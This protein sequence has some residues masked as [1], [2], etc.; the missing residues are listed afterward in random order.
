M[1]VRVRVRVGLG[2]RLRLRLKL[3]LSLRLRLRLL[4]YTTCCSLRVSIMPTPSRSVLSWLG[5]G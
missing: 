1:G 3:R 5:L 2:L 4:P